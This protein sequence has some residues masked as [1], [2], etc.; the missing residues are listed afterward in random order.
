MARLLR[1][2]PVDVPIHI[3]QWGSNRQ[4]YFVSDEDHRSYA[5]W[6]KEYSK[7]DHV[8]IHA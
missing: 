4:V 8:E 3:I 7:K 1:I 2:S 6:L 5:G